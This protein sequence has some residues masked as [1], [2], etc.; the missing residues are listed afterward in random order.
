TGRARLAQGGGIESLVRSRFRGRI[1]RRRPDG[2]PERDAPPPRKCGAGGA[3]RHG[4]SSFLRLLTRRPRARPRGSAA[5]WP[6][7]AQRTGP[8]DRF[9]PLGWSAPATVRTVT[10]YNRAGKNF[11]TPAYSSDAIVFFAF[12]Q[13]RIDLDGI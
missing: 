13:H 4:R 1:L 3:T 6:R 2:P 7:P 9:Q 10:K 5:P 12:P 8:P 11:C